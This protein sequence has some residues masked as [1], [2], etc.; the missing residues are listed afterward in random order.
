MFK[1]LFIITILYSHLSRYIDDIYIAKWTIND[2]KL[3]NLKVVW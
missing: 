3:G 2:T 1:I